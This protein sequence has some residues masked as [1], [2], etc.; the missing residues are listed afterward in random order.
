VARL[1][2]CGATEDFAGSQGRSNV[3]TFAL[4]PL[5]TTTPKQAACMKLTGKLRTRCL[6]LERRATELRRCAKLKPAK[7]TACVAAAQAA[8]RRATR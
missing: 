8:F 7:R 6:A 3:F 5:G 1:L 2:G 4:L